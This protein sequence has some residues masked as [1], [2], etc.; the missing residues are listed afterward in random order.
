M[1]AWIFVGL[2][3]AI[4]QDPGVTEEIV[5]WGDLFARWDD[6]RWMVTTETLL[7]Y[8]LTLARDENEAFDS[9]QFQLRTVFACSKDW[10]L[11]PKRY[12][13][14]CVI[15]DFA[16][17]A[18]VAERRV[19]APD[20]ERAQRVLDEIDAKL[21]GA[22]L[23]LQ[24]A[25]DGRVTNLSLDGVPKNNRRQ[26]E[27]HET[28]RQIL[29]RVVVGFDLKLR[30]FNQ[31]NEGKWH[32]YNTKL[33]S[34]PVPPSIPASQ[35]SSLVVHYLNPYKGHIIVQSIGK[36]LVTVEQANFTL[37]L[38]GVSTFDDREG[39]MRERVW[40]LKGA[41]TASTQF[42]LGPYFNAGRICNLGDTNKPDCGPTQVVSGRDQPVE[43]L[44]VWKSIEDT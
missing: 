41:N 7:P 10:K 12:E 2:Q 40:A 26:S 34:M 33:M 3:A 14:S 44:P 38:T 29:S 5:V 9:R 4:A 16:M 6:T 19:T 11:G 37:E 17:L 25:H 22:K 15:E 35:G 30:K 36:G 43:G 24:V 28:L 21:T 39:Y 18:A 13:V 32:E 1:I 31:L 20:I 27:M 23:Q 8:A 42:N